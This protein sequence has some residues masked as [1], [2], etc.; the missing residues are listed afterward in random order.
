MFKTS[1]TGAGLS[2]ARVRGWFANLLELLQVRIELL[3]I[4]TRLEVH[5][6]LWIAALGLLG[7]LCVAF[8]IMF[9]A[10]FIT[11][12]LW[13]THALLALGIITALFLGGGITLALMAK[14]R[15]SGLSDMF[16]GTREELRRDQ[17]RLRGEPT[18]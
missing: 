5:R 7:V 11:V 8:G 16:S 15:L 10:I 1:S 9:L 18:P 12:A 13:Q 6:L 3:G 2:E 14:A 4:E 17:Q